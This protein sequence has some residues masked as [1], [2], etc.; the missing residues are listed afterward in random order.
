MK[1]KPI[2]LTKVLPW[3]STTISFQPRPVPPYGVPS[4]STT[5]AGLVST[6]RPSGSQSIENGR[7]RHRQLD[8]ALPRRRRT[9]APRPAIQSQTHSLP[10]CQR[11]D[12]PMLRPLAKISMQVRPPPDRSLIGR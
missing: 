11:G 5:P 2:S 7:T 9:R 12:S 3:A 4:P 10:A 8:P 1:S 6:A